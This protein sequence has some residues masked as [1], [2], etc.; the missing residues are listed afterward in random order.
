MAEEELKAYDATANGGA[1]AFILEAGDYWFTA[2]DHAHEAVNN[3][4]AAK[5]ASGMDGSGNA[6]NVKTFA[7]SA[8]DKYSLSTFTGAPIANRFTDAD[9]RTYDK[10]T[11]GRAPS[12]RPMN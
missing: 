11:T 9:M 7:L 1:G 4:L 10:E 8:S 5:G 6:A 2:A 3:I 12:P